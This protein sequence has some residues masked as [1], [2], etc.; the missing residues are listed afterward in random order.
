LL[1]ED[2]DRIGLVGAN[3]SGKSTLVRILAGRETPDHGEVQRQGRLGL[4]EQDPDLRGETVGEVM[5]AA[6]AWHRALVSGH[7]AA[8]AAGEL[9]KA[10]ALQDRL[11]A[12]GWTIDHR[13]D[14][15]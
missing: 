6:D 3:G 7:Q 13:I 4:L 15:M 9:A 1:V 11:D 14:G 10:A 12:E 2:G 5:E 8:L